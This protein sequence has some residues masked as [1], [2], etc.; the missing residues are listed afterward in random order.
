M[1]DLIISAHAISDFRALKKFD[2][3]NELLSISKKI[4]QLGGQIIIRQTFTNAK[5]QDIKIFA[6]E[7]EINQWEK[8]IDEFL[9]VLETQDS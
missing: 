6:T 7:E 8:D 3:I 9:K 4:I 5:P 1:V 2:S